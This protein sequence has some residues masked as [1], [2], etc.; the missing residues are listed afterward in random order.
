[1]SEDEARPGRPAAPPGVRK[2]AAVFAACFLLSIGGPVG[3][4]TWYV[5]SYAQ[6]A[7]TALNVLTATPLKPPANPAANPSR[8]QAY[9]LYLGLKLWALEDRC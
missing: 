5:A 7:C 8:E 6:H 9:R 4:T 1:M 2:W 3:Y